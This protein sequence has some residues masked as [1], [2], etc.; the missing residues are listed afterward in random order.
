MDARGDP[1]IGGTSRLFDRVRGGA[2]TALGGGMPGAAECGGD[3]SEYGAARVVVG[4]SHSA[5]AVLV[6][7]A[8]TVNETP[9]W[10]VFFAGAVIVLGCLW[11]LWQLGKL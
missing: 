4:L 8:G 7:A 9:R 2:G 10:V 3:V 6:L 11:V 5:V 1:E